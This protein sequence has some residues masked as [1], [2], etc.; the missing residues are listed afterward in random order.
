MAGTNTFFTLS[1]NGKFPPPSKA[2]MPSVTTVST[3][4]VRITT[5]KSGPLM[6]AMPEPP[7]PSIS[8]ICSSKAVFELVSGPATDGLLAKIATVVELINNMGSNALGILMVFDIFV[9]L[10]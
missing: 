8:F 10:V 2:A 5:A 4:I 9:L 6:A 1:V 7:E 3:T